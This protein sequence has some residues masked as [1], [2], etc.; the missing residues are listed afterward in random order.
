[1]DRKHRDKE[2]REKNKEKI[3]EYREKNKEKIKEYREKNKE[4]IKELKKQYYQNNK[5]KI[6][7]QKKKYREN[8]KEYYREK[9]KEY[10]QTEQGK[11]SFKISDWKRAGVISDDFNSLYEHYINCKNCEECNVELQN[12]NLVNKRCLDHDH[13]TGLFRNVLCNSCNLKRH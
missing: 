3:K 5:E 9:Q 1:M 13:K 6:K 11:K 12:G 2:Y 8:N 4:K 7:E 10:Q